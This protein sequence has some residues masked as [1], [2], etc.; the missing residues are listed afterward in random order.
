MKSL[1]NQILILSLF[2]I[3]PLIS[4]GQT[5]D[6]KKEK[7]NFKIQNKE[8]FFKGSPFSGKV[9]CYYENGKLQS[10]SS[11]KDGRPDGKSVQYFNDGTVVDVVYYKDGYL[12]GIYESH[13]DH[14]QLYFRMTYLNGKLDG[15]YEV[16]Y[17]DGKKKEIRSYKNG[18]REGTFISYHQNGKIQNKV[19]FLNNKPVSDFPSDEE[20]DDISG[21]GP[22]DVLFI[23]PIY[24]GLNIYSCIN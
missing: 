8:V 22:D 7:L 24:S 12:N 13:Y 9:V 16:Y 10:E 11:F 17:P 5:I 1:K 20:E 6:G 14:G 15:T 4:C 18:M 2:L 3:I 19:I 21:T 23:Y